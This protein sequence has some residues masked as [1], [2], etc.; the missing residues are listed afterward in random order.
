[1]ERL[2]DGIWRWTARHPEWHPRTAFGAAVASYALRD[3]DDT[4]VVDP[5]APAGDID[6]LIGALDAIVSGRVRIVITMPYHVRDAEP[7]WRRYRRDHRATIWGH[8]AVAKRLADGRGFREIAAGTTIG[9]G[10]LPIAVGNPRRHEMPLFVR[11]H[12]ALA[13]GD[14][15]VEADGVA[16][17]WMQRPITPERL[18]WYERR[19]R[20]SLQP[21]L[22]VDC[23][24]LLVTHGEPVL[25]GGNDALRTALDAGPWYHPPH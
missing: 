17:V 8:G 22:D 2:A 10:I 3:G 14:T 24:R 15:V 5:I 25:S 11:E 18:R 4:I 19:L 9:T 12:R 1:M 13:F 23:D 7:L 6:A 20:P 21:L 16:R